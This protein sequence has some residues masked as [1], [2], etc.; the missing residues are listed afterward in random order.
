MPPRKE[1]QKKKETLARTNRPMRRGPKAG[2][3]FENWRYPALPTLS[4]CGGEYLHSGY[5]D[6]PRHV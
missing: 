6:A 5:L 3:F 2:D 1:R 4:D